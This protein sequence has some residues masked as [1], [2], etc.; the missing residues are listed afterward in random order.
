MQKEVERE[1][2]KCMCVHCRLSR[3]IFPSLARGVLVLGKGMAW[4]RRHWHVHASSFQFNFFLYFFLYFSAR[5]LF[6]AGGCLASLVSL[7]ICTVVALLGFLVG[8]LTS[9]S[10]GDVM[11]MDGMG[12][13]G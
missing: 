13:D 9:G 12:W 2:K 11:I 4:P 10:R 5:S 7:Y 8:L 6:I 1:K 3:I